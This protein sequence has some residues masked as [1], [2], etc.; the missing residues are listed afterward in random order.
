[1]ESILTLANIAAVSPAWTAFND[2]FLFWGAFSFFATTA[3]VHL[4]LRVRGL[5]AR[6]QSR[7]TSE[8]ME[9]AL[10]FLKEQ[11]RYAGIT[12]AA[13]QKYMGVPRAAAM[14]DLQKLVELGLLKPPSKTRRAYGLAIQKTIVSRKGARAIQN[15]SRKPAARIASAPSKLPA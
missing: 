1:M 10:Q 6:R 15:L 4:A 13:Y 3:S 14:R 7:A 8:R 12:P 5:R 2:P 9:K 11:R